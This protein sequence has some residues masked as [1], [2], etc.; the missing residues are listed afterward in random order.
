MPWQ[1][2]IECK[3]EKIYWMRVCS[4]SAPFV[5]PKHH[6]RADV[7]LQGMVLALPKHVAQERKCTLASCTRRRDECKI[8]YNSSD[9]WQK[10]LVQFEE[11]QYILVCLHISWE[12]L[13]LI[14]LLFHSS[15]LIHWDE[16][17]VIREVGQ[18]SHGFCLVHNN[19][20]SDGWYRELICERAMSASEP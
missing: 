11:S 4:L 3:G 12:H 20:D 10:I 8:T 9:C 19:C 1:Y 17:A 14:P 2:E 18:V 15:E 7:I 16:R 6:R 13:V 5:G